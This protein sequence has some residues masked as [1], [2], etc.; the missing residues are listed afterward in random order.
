MI[1]VQPAAAGLRR[2][3]IRSDIFRGLLC[4]YAR[5]SD[6]IPNAQR[7]CNLQQLIAPIDKPR[8]CG[9]GTCR[10]VIVAL[11][12]A[13]ERVENLRGGCEFLTVHHV[14]PFVCEKK[15]SDFDIRIRGNRNV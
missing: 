1:L 12:T 2:K 4:K 7:T 8:F 5:I 15:A 3:N 11:G 13:Y 10:V 6:G 14:P 9:W